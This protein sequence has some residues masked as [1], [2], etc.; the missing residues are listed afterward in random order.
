MKGRRLHL[1]QQLDGGV[2]RRLDGEE[3]VVAAARLGRQTLGDFLLN[4]ENRARKAQ[5]N[6]LFQDRRRDVVWQVAG[7]HRRAPAREIGIEHVRAHHFQAR[8]ARES[9]FQVAGQVWIHLDG[10]D[11][12][13]ALQEFFGQRAAA[14]TDLDRQVLRRGAGSRGDSLQDGASDQ[15]MLPESGV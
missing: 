4:Q 15:E 12:R 13:G 11:P 2:E 1:E 3:P 9:V 5:A 14:G 7:D 6:R 8:L 10:D